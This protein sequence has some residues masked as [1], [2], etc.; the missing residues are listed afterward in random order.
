MGSLHTLSS[1][2]PTGFAEKG[3]YAGIF[4]N[5]FKERKRVDLGLYSCPK[6]NEDLNEEL[7][8]WWNE[9]KF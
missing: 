2:I 3:G 6:V 7:R 9:R 8:N 4:I 1:Y 5:S